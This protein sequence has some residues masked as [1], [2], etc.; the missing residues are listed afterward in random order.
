[1]PKTTRSSDE[2]T[3]RIR[4]HVAHL[5][6]AGDRHPGTERNRAATDYVASVM[7]DLGLVVDELPFE[8]P[9]WQPGDATITAGTRE[10][11]MHPGPFSTSVEAD[12]PLV[13]ID[14]AADLDSLDARGCVVLVHGEIAQ[15]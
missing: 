5:C 6:A 12:G 9:D 7:R 3:A 1:M 2:L 13:L 15:I 4:A 14:R 8:V 10:F 11:W